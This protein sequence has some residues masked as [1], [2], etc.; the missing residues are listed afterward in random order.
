M[1]EVIV[2]VFKVIKVKA[3]DCEVSCKVYKVLLAAGSVRE[4]CQG[5]SIG[6]TFKL[7]LN[8]GFTYVFNAVVEVI[9][10]ETEYAQ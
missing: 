2:G 1:A 3:Y 9:K 5:V 6:K 10:K 8:S 7:S 4:V